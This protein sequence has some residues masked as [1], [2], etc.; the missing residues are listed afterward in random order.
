M[1]DTPEWRKALRDLA[2]ISTGVFLLVHEAF[3]ETPNEKRMYVGAALLVGPAF[4]RS[5]G[6]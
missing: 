4:L 2:A 1:P 5:L 6:K 3:V